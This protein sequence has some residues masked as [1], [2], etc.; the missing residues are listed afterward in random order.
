MTK[1]YFLFKSGAQ[2]HIR[3]HTQNSLTTISLE[4]IDNEWKIRIESDLSVCLCFSV[5]LMR[6]A[7]INIATLCGECILHAIEL[8]ALL[9]I[10]CC[11]R[12]CCCCCWLCENYCPPF[13]LISRSLLLAAHF[14]FQAQIIFIWFF[15][16]SQFIL[17]FAH[18]S[19]LPLKCFFFVLK[20]SF[21]RVFFHIFRGTAINLSTSHS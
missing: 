2:T 17:R 10:M 4:V 19:F 1:M 18:I 5:V 11:C 7:G 6:S 3:T 14:Q 20:W 21:L 8:P 15:F 12:C 9:V 16:S 13:C